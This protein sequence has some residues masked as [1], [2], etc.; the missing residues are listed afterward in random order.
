MPNVKKNLRRK[1][2][3]RLRQVFGGTGCGGKPVPG[4][5]VRDFPT[6]CKGC[7]GRLVERPQIPGSDPSRDQWRH[8]YRAI[9]S[10]KDSDAPYA[11]GGCQPSCRVVSPYLITIGSVD[12]DRGVDQACG[13]D[14]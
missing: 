2:T 6:R 8:G 11:A 7:W 4:R 5:A 14:R 9:R 1:A 3:A 10:G 13:V 12:E